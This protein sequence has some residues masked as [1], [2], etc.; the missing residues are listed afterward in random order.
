MTLGSILGFIIFGLIVGAI[1]RLLVPGRDPMGWVATI[2]LGIVG[3]LIGGA[4]AYALRLGTEP[5][6]PAGWIF[7]ILGAVLALVG[8][9]SLMG[10]KK[11]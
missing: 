3:S 7:S 6:Q 1:G 11:T 8:Y 2:L 4:I 10:I 9:Y 5:F